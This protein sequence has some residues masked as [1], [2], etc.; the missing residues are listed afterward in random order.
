MTTHP[1]DAPILVTG[2]H[3]TGTTWVGKML[4]AG[5][6]A[7]YISEPLN[8]WHRPGVLGAAVRHWYQYIDES[9][10]EHFLPALRQTLAYKY[11][12]LAEIR[13]LHSRKELLTLF[14]RH[15]LK[16]LSH[17]RPGILLFFRAHGSHAPL[18]FGRVGGKR[19]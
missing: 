6:Q 19:F 18:K 3:R 2:A 1:D 9:N 15:F 12:L 13:S 11:H 16:L 17:L 7:A 10:Q 5:G 8:V 14:R 4:A